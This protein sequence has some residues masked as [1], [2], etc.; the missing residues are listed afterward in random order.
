MTDET[1]MR[2]MTASATTARLLSRIGEGD[3]DAV[4]GLYRDMRMPIYLLAASIL[5][6]HAL[7]EEV[8][9]ET[10]L[11]VVAKASSYRPAGSARAWV[12]RIAQN[13][14]IDMLRHERRS[15]PLQDTHAREDEGL[16]EADTRADFLAATEGFSNL[17]K[18][19]VVLRVFAGMSHA[20]IADAVGVTASV[21]RTRYHRALKR[22]RAFYEQRS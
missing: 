4:A 6:S 3:T 12:M 14:A 13:T 18:G 9:Q 21:S 19:I 2:L 17:D 16:E 11:K 1:R 20:E 15:A 10:F 7:A 5:G 8:V 22:L